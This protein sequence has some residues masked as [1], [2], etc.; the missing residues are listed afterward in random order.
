[1]KK[2]SKKA[3]EEMES[4]YQYLFEKIMKDKRKDLSL[5]V[6]SFRE[7]LIKEEKL[8]S[9]S[10][11]VA[12]D[13]LYFHSVNNNDEPW[14][15]REAANEAF[16]VLESRETSFEK[17]EAI[18]AYLQLAEVFNYLEDVDKE[19]L[20]YDHASYLAFLT[21]D[22]EK[23][24]FAKEN[25]IKLVW[26]YPEEERKSLFPT[27]ETL[28][29]QFGL[30][31]GKRLF[32]LESVEPKT[33][34]DPIETNPLFTK[35]IDKVNIALKEYFDKNKENFTLENYN[36]RKHKML[37]EYGIDWKAPY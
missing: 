8:R 12:L 21:K 4:S 28:M 2:L 1:M 3:T 13:I 37:L 32:E 27:K 20:S 25:E 30:T 6:G 33:H 35:I 16:K 36:S 18:S 23:S 26:R 7:Q 10:D 31:E 5:F 34:H 9:Y 24:V 14:K 11:L 22:R 19:R 17:D 15:G 29:L